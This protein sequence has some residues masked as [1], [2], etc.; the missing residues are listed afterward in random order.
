M[1]TNIIKPIT[2]NHYLNK[3]YFKKSIHT[4]IFDSNKLLSAIADLERFGIKLKKFPNLVFFGP[5]SSGKSSVIQ[6]I[7]GNYILPTD[8]KMATKKP[9]H[10][11]TLR[12]NTTKYK[13]CDKEFNNVTDVAQEIKR[14]NDNEIVTKIDV[15]VSGPNVHNSTF[16][17]LPGLFSVSDETGDDFRKD[18]KNMTLSYVSNKNF[19][20]VI[21]HAAPQ[22]QRRIQQ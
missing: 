8:M 11:T 10:V 3:N 17:D 16:I 15:L 14:L 21:V 20:P 4:Q 22:I 7:T 9:I 2:N 12:S 18:V 5:Q 19:I 13:I 1:F 6:A